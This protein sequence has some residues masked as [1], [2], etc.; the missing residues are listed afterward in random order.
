MEPVHNS[1]ETTEKKP[2]GSK[3]RPALQVTEER[4]YSVLQVA[5]QFSAGEVELL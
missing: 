5:A 2:Q 1:E 4:R 3:T